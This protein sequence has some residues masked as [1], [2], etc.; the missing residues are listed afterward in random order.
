MKTMASTFTVFK[1]C[2]RLK[3]WH[4][5]LKCIGNPII[6]LRVAIACD[7]KCNSTQ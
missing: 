3:L 6:R 7:E 1:A 4:N 2:Y 5:H